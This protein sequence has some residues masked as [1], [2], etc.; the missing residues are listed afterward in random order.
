[1]GHVS[2]V[3]VGGELFDM[4]ELAPEE[5]DESTVIE[6]VVEVTIAVLVLDEFVE[7]AKGQQSGL[8]LTHPMK[9]T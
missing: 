5:L 4:L 6:V 9:G 2:A 1:M 3:D 7:T 8:S